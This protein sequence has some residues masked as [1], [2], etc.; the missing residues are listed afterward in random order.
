[1]V[2]HYLRNKE[3]Y[4]FRRN[5]L[6]YVTEELKNPLRLDTLCEIYSISLSK[7]LLVLIKE[8]PCNYDLPKT[9]KPN[10]YE[11]AKWENLAPVVQLFSEIVFR[12]R[13]VLLMSFIQC[14]MLCYKCQ[15]V[16]YELF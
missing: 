2:F 14:H 5:N 8:R 6:N 1:M 15:L 12:I 4:V 11:L 3:F 7:I 10:A 13:V 16:Y 9:H